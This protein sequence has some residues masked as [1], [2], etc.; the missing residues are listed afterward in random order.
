MVIFFVFEF[1]LNFALQ[2][3]FGARYYD[4]D[5]GLWTSCDPAAENWSLYTAFNNNPIIFVDP[6]GTENTV[7]LRNIGST[8]LGNNYAT[9]LENQI[10]QSGAP[11]L[12]VKEVGFWGALFRTRDKTDMLLAMTDMKKSQI[13]SFSAKAIM[14]EKG[15]IT[16]KEAG[17][18]QSKYAEV[19]TD[20]AMKN[21]GLLQT[22][23]TSVHEIGHAILGSM[24]ILVV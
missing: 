22:L 23:K 5:I 19:W 10:H 3:L 12:K 2:T 4:A 18:A 17:A 9:T 16:P 13:G 24:T 8:P 11:N 15:G 6:D 21:G 20:M 7:Y 1:K 14:I